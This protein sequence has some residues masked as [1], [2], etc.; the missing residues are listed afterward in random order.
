MAEWQPIE[1]APKD[2][3]VIILADHRGRVVASC[4]TGDEEY[5]WEFLD[6]SDTTNGWDAHRPTHWQ[7]LPEPPQ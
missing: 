3:N 7:P 2:G 1:T 6:G 4:W 5:P